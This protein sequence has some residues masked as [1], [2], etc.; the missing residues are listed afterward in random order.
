MRNHQLREVNV[1]RIAEKG[2]VA[3]IE[4]CNVSAIRRAKRYSN[5]RRLK[6]VHWDKEG[7]DKRGFLRTGNKIFQSAK[8]MR[9]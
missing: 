5:R 6:R 7:L 2:R 9:N 3:I 4:L 8:D 1:S